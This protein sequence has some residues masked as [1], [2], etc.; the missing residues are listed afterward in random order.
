MAMTS[1]ALL[2]GTCAPKLSVSV[3]ATNGD[4][5]PMHCYRE[6]T[7]DKGA[8]AYALEWP[9]DDNRPPVI[10]GRYQNG[11]QGVRVESF[12]IE[13]QE[14]HYSSIGAALEYCDNY[15]SSLE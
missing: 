10:V 14:F 11:P 4:T 1:L 6:Y 3:Q 15:F 9:R 12:R 8:R 13:G 7:P 2:L 5:F